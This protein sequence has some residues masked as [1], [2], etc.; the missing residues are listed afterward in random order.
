MAPRPNFS[1][2]CAVKP[3]EFTFTFA[4]N[5]PQIQPVTLVN[6]KRHPLRGP[7]RIV[8]VDFD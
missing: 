8:R 2:F 4:S 3:L 5:P 7:I 1:T 6:P